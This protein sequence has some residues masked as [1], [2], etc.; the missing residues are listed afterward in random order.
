MNTISK[1]HRTNKRV[2]DWLILSGF[3][4]IYMFPHGRFSRG[5]YINDFEFDGIA[6]K[7]NQIVLFQCKSNCK[8]TKKMQWKYKQFSKEYNCLALWFNAVDRK[9]LEVYGL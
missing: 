3:K 8:P 5:F 4:E 1:M 6:N 7:E 9:D 2:K